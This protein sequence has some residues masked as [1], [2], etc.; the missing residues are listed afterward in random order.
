MT[1]REQKRGLI[2]AAIAMLAAPAMLLA[3][4][5]PAAF[6]TS[7]ADPTTVGGTS[8]T[9]DG[10]NGT[11]VDGNGGT[12]DVLTDNSA[13]GGS[14]NGSGSV[15]QAVDGSGANGSGT[16]S[17]TNDNG[18]SAT[19]TV[20]GP[21]PNIIITNFNYGDGTVSAGGDF[22]LTFTFQNMGKVA[23]DNMVVTVDGGESFAI[24]GGTNTFYFDRLGAGYAMTQS[25]PMQAVANAQSGAQGI[26]VSF[27][28]EYVDGGARSS[29]SSD[30]KISV[31]ISQPDRFELNDP[32]LP[33][34]ATVGSETTITMNYVNKGKGDIANVEASIEGEG[35]QVT[36]AKQYVGNVTSGSTGS[37]GFAFT[38]TQAGDISAKLRVT[39]EDS[40]GKTQTKEFPVTIT[41]ADAE[42]A[43]PDDGTVMPDDNTVDQQG[44]PGWVWA[45]VA[46]VV[47]AAVIVTVVLVRRHRKKAKQADIDEEWDDWTGAGGTTDAAGKGGGEPSTDTI[48][49]PVV[50]AAGNIAT[51]GEG[52]A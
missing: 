28:Y 43:M 26:T 4:V 51:S 45:V 40:D 35:L 39:Y 17:G 25:L 14:A 7:T 34:G 33:E 50:G 9:A 38:P 44:I 15:N 20:A 30:I 11:T 47:L 29:N 5:T 46:V 8:E 36:N 1:T 10:T 52:R 13:N 18:G 41:A 3:C 37:I 24:A 22:N 27:K 19:Q 49:V 12:G 31:P 42:P 21:V 23:V 48:D 16:D 2:A 6:A 32:V